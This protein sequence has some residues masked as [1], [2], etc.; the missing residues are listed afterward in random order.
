MV[1]F[2]LKVTTAS[3][4]GC[5]SVYYRWREWVWGGSSVDESR[6]EFKK[7]WLRNTASLTGVSAAFF[8]ILFWSTNAL[9]AKFALAE[10]GVVQV[11][12]LQFGGAT[13]TLATLRVLRAARAD[14]KKAN[15]SGEVVKWSSLRSSHILDGVLVGVVGL[16]ATIFLQYLAFATAPIVE[17]NVVA[18]GWPL[19]AALW[20]ALAYRSRQTLAGVPLAI[21]GFVGVA[22]ILSSGGSIGSADGGTAGYVAAL[23]SA[24]CMAFFTVMSGRSPYPVSTF[25]LPATAFGM[26]FALV[27]CVTGFAPWLWSSVSVGA[28]VASVYAGVGPMAGGFWLWSVAMSGGG[29]KRLAPLGYATPLLSTVLLLLF[30]ETFTSTTLFGALLV[31]VC[32]IG[33]LMM[34]RKERD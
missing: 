10:L 17:A 29:A 7:T 15:R 9:A 6:D 33:V 31:L 2:L 19:F 26:V 28:W 27:L 8:A 1:R 16:T 12:A 5:S 11:L 18:Y 23:A 21:I 24:V 32:S 20:A 4:T 14:A 3:F 13:A 22:L 34:D 25:L 30:G